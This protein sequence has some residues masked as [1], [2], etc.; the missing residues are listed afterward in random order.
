MITS[1]TPDYREIAIQKLFDAAVTAVRKTMPH[2][3]PNQQERLARYVAETDTA[4]ADVRDENSFMPREV[5]LTAHI[6]ALAYLKRPDAEAYRVPPSVGDLE[7]AIIAAEN[8]QAPGAKM[9]L[10]RE[11][12]RLTPDELLER[13]RGLDLSAATA[14]DTPKQTAAPNAANKAAHEMTDQELA[15]LVGK[16]V[17]RD[18]RHMLASEI[19]KIGHELQEASRPPTTPALDTLRSKLQSGKTWHQISGIERITAEREAKD[20]L[21]KTLR[22]LGLGP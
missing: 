1:G 9:S 21:G 14:T 8:I 12:A 17:G 4:Y 20:V 16:T 18:P 10:H 5:D 19:R 6:E 22:E 11:L 3:T 2:L 7:R 13:S 15:D